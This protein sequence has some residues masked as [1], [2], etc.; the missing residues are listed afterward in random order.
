MTVKVAEPRV[1]VVAMTRLAAD[2]E[3]FNELDEEGLPPGPDEER[4]ET[5]REFLESEGCTFQDDI[6]NRAGLDDEPSDYDSDLD[7][8]PEIAGRVCYDS[9]GRKKDSNSRYV[10]HII[11]VGHG[12]VLEHSN[13]T[14]AFIGIS[15]TLTHELVRHRAGFG[16]SQRSQRFVNESG[17]QIVVPPLFNQPGWEELSQMVQDASEKA[18]EAYGELAEKALKKLSTPEA[19]VQ[20][21]IREGV[22]SNIWIHDKG[23]PVTNVELEADKDKLIFTGSPEDV[24]EKYR[25][26]LYS[27]EEWIEH[28]NGPMG[29]VLDVAT[30]TARR[31]TARE[32]ARSVLPNCT[33]TKIFVTGNLRAWRTMLDQRAAIT[34]DREIRRLAIMVLKALKSAAPNVFADY[35]IKTDVEGLEYAETKHR[36]V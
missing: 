12:S 36:K 35:T 8:L 16:Y 30:K 33:E 1:F 23:R 31:K 15:R 3:M 34:A 10:G 13:V 26:K 22:L 7:L 17:F 29:G 21:A 25:G 32:A 6:W 4:I 2:L 20:F 27:K 18:L 14:L 9:Y 11:E 28:A 24:G 5:L 19:L